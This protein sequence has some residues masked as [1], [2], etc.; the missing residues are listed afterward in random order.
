MVFAGCLHLTEVL[1]GAS[2]PSNHYIHYEVITA[3]DK[4]N[5][6]EVMLSKIA[7]AEPK[8]PGLSATTDKPHLK[9]FPGVIEEMILE[10]PAFSFTTIWN[11]PDEEKPDDNSKEE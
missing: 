6:E 5:Q 4:Y 11:T 8:S 1:D 9:R 10:V 2:I 3:V 7:D